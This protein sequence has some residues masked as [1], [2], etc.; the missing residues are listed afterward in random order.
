MSET[1]EAACACKPLSCDN[2]LSHD[3]GLLRLGH[4]SRLPLKQK[5]F[6]MESQDSLFVSLPV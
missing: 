6:E 3:S 4:I 2:A 1:L 5:D